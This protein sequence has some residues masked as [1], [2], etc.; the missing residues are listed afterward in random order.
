MNILQLNSSDFG[1]GAAQIA[2][3]LF[4]SYITKGLHSQLWVGKKRS[5]NAAVFQLTNRE[6]LNRWESINFTAADIA[7]NFIGTIRGAGRVANLFE[8]MARYQKSYAYFRGYEDFYY[9]NSKKLVPLIQ[10]NNYDILQCHNLHG[11]YFDL[12][13]LPEISQKIPTVLTLHDSWLL[14]GHC[15][16]SLECNRWISGCGNCP[17]LSLYPAIHRDNTAKNWQIKKNI[18]KKSNLYLITPSKWLMNKVKISPLF[19]CIRLAKVINNG[20]DIQKF[21]PGDQKL[22]RKKLSLPSDEFLL[23]FV[24]DSPKTNIWKDFKTIKKALIILSEQKAED[25]KFRLICVGSESLSEYA[26]EI[27]ITFI[28]Y[29]GDSE[30]LVSFYQAA[31]AYI[32]ASKTDTFPTVI[33]EALACG[34]PVVATAVDGVSEQIKSLN[35]LEKTESFMEKITTVDKEQAT[36]VLVERGNAEEIA[37][38]IKVFSNNK[39]L[40][41]QLSQNARSDALNR[42]D[43]ERQV[44]DYLNFYREAIEDFKQLDFFSKK[45]SGARL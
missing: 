31:N 33:L 32:H 44:N 7:K 43:F 10:K 2:Y 6:P 17:D 24:A 45:Q 27:P 38:W 11:K 4:L 37:K 21:C 1:G 14:S 20:V 3:N 40:L 9:P 19:E 30:I 12:R 5:N 28:P 42:F 23:L 35:S 22:A 18:Y 15:A 36:G 16:Q 34:L 25:V 13:L 41:A 39:N 8:N 26:G 29:T